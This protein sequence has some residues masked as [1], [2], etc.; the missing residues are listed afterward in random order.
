MRSD[1]AL[2]GRN[3]VVWTEVPP[4]MAT[5]DA[6]ARTTSRRVAIGVVATLAA[7]I[8]AVALLWVA[9]ELHY[10][11]CVDRAVAE[12]P[13]VPVSAYVQRNRSNVGPLKV[14]FS[15]QRAAAVNACHHF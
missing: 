14:S 10:R 8:A 1:P 2:G 15:A 5:L 12:F 11:S 7:V 13:T 6:G 9:D 3:S 4:T